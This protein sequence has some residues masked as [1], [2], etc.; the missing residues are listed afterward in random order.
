MKSQTSHSMHLSFV[1]LLLFLISWASASSVNYTHG[2]FLQCLNNHST[3]ISQ[4]IYTP[5]NSSYSSI[6]N[7]AIYNQRFTSPNT[8]KPM[9]IVTPV[10]ESQIQAV[11]YCSKRHGLHMSIRGGGHDFEGLSY[12]SK[13][14][15]VLLDMFNL[16]SIS[17]DV[18]NRTAW[19]QGGANLGEL[20][21]SIAEKSST[22]GFPGGIWATVGVGGHL[23]GGGYGLMKRKYGLAADQVIDA[24]LI[25]VNG[26]ILDRKSM[27]EDLFWAIRGGGGSTFGVII[28]WKVMLVEVPKIVTVFRV[29]RTFEQNAVKLLHRWQYVAPN[30]DNDLYIRPLFRSTITNVVVFNSLYLGGV[31]KLLPLMQKGFPELA[32]VREDCVEMSWIESVQ[33]FSSFSLEQPRDILL[34]RSATPRFYQ[35]GKSDFVKEPISE[36]G[37]ETIWK[38]FFK[39]KSVPAT[40]EM[41]PY[42]G[43][44]S[45][46]SE[47][48]IPFPHRAGNL[49]MLYEG[50]SWDAKTPSKNILKRLNWLRGFNS[51]LGRYVSNLPRAAYVNYIDLDFGVGNKTFAQASTW[52][53]RYFKNNFKRLVQVKYKVDPDNF[54]NHLQSIPALPLQ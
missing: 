30:I 46:I 5:K 43:R 17:V 45:E 18:G 20:Y 54:F 27:G 2:D 52:G 38:M 48:A 41:S 9:L 49:Y 26:R 25:D 44:M 23:S 32:L 22:L 31:D 50:V 6:L 47:S 3:S 12:V 19:V 7:S 34:N 51:Y 21:Y 16:R 35:K 42:G 37:I 15:F 13:V 8:P 11:I 29:N 1:S 40:L 33:I 24:R 10:H 28:A 53:T 4:V 14:A 36:K 39:H